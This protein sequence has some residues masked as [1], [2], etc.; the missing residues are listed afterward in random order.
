MRRA[1]TS[2]MQRD[3]GGRHLSKRKQLFLGCMRPPSPLPLPPSFKYLTKHF[4]ENSS[5]LFE[6][7]A[8]VVSNLASFLIHGPRPSLE[9]C[10][11]NLS[12]TLAESLADFFSF[13]PPLP[14]PRLNLTGNI[15]FPRDF[16]VL[17]NNCK[18]VIYH[19]SHID[20]LE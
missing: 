19:F 12:P 3:E 15:L 9:K 10:S 4:S 2:A 18:I 20:E 8:R 7:L 6:N 11:L 5:P 16:S 14:S 1:R 17:R 13:F